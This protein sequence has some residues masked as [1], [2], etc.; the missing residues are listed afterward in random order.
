MTVA[1][2]ADAMEAELLCNELH[3][4]G[5]PA[6]T[7]NENIVSA[8]QGYVGFVRVEVQVAVEDADRAAA[9]LARLPGRND[10]EPEEEAADGSAD[11]ATDEGG[12]R[13]PL[14]MAAEFDTAQEMLE[15]AATL[16]AARVR[17]FLPDLVPRRAAPDAGGTPRKFKVRVLSE[18]VARAG[19]ALE[20]CAAEDADEGDD[21]RCPKCAS[22]RVHGTSPGIIQS[23]KRLLGGGGPA[24]GKTWECLRCGFKWGAAGQKP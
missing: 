19:L 15:A 5:I 24:P 4:D 10:V 14:A 12:T 18:D 13:V 1:W 22:W 21:P 8:L 17:T 20:R 6:V 7:A 11:F 2:C 23:V 3:A 16:G 9:V